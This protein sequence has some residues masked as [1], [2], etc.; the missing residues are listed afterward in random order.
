MKKYK[1]LFL[2]NSKVQLKNIVVNG[3]VRTKRDSFGFSFIEANDGSCLK[4][5]SDNC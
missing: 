2:L 4:K 5:H 1:I 3:W